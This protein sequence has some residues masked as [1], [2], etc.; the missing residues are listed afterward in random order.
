M[1]KADKME[2]D[3]RVVYEKA[4]DAVVVRGRKDFAA[5]RIVEGTEGALIEIERLRS[6]RYHTTAETS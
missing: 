4:I 3:E 6:A 5:G 1:V 2:S